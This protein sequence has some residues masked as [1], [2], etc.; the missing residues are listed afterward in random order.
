MGFPGEE[1]KEESSFGQDHSGQETASAPPSTIRTTLR[2]DDTAD[3]AD[4]DALS[5]SPGNRRF[6]I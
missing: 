1:A 2:I 6:L 4:A 3:A 5:A